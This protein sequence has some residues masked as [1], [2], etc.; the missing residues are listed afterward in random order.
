MSVGREDEHLHRRCAIEG[1]ARLGID[2][3]FPW[4]TEWGRDTFISLPGLTLGRGQL[5][6]CEEVLSRSLEFLS[7]GLLPN[8]FGL[9][10]ESS[11][12]GS[13]DASLWY[14][15]AGDASNALAWLR[16][17]Y[18]DRSPDLVYVGVRAELGFL[19]AE[20]GF[21]ELLERMELPS[22]DDAGSF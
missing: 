21:R 12:Y 16:R 18:D 22:P 5:E 20:A 6:T 9:T 11:H 1:A 2:A 7:D 17:A 14:A 13:V 4:F 3:G 19:R 8:I 10:R 15:R